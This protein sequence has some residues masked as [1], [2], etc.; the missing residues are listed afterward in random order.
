MS[1]RLK[2]RYDV[3][4]DLMTIE[5]LRFAG[6]FFRQFGHA[7]PLD[8]P[9]KITVREDGFITVVQIEPG[10][11]DWQGENEI[12]KG[13]RS[14]LVPDV[15]KEQLAQAL[16]DLAHAVECEIPSTQAPALI[17]PPGHA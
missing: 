10:D 5:G 4:K 12:P 15:P 6:D 9:M 1:Q 13:F 3:T 2:Y 11:P 7:M 8:T 17:L 16:R 14:M